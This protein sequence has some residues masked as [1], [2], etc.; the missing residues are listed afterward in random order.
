MTEPVDTITLT[1]EMLQLS[2]A[3]E[4]QVIGAL[5]SHFATYAELD[6]RTLAKFVAEAQA[7][8]S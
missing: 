4:R 5:A 8:T 6:R 7:V 3:A 1:H 2:S